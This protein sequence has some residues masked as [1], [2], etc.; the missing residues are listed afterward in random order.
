M[1]VECE[2]KGRWFREDAMDV[3]EDVPTPRLAPNAIV[4]KHPSTSSLLL[5]RSTLR[6]KFAN[7]SNSHITLVSLLVLVSALLI[8]N[9]FTMVRRPAPVPAI[10]AVE[11]FHKQSPEDASMKNGLFREYNTE[12]PSETAVLPLFSLKHKTAIVSGSDRGIGLVV[13]QA[14]AEAGANVAIWYH[15]NKKA[16][17]RAAEIV[18]KYGV[19]CA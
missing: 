19:K 2:V 7:G 14:F 12:A 17:D 8:A 4:I 18:E 16:H 11:Q 5:F 15:S 13:A 9:L 3:S 6:M 1:Y 10:A